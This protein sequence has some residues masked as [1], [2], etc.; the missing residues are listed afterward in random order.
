MHTDSKLLAASYLVIALIATFIGVKFYQTQSRAMSVLVPEQPKRVAVRTVVTR[1]GSRAL[2]QQLRFDLKRQR[3]Q[4]SELQQLLGKREEMLATQTRELQQ[5]TSASKK[6]DAEA[7]RYFALLIDLLHESNE[8]LASESAAA[9]AVTETEVILDPL[10]DELEPKSP[11]SL[12]TELALATWELDR[13]QSSDQE[14]QVALA[15]ATKRSTALQQSLVDTGEAAIP[16]L[17]SLLANEDAGLRAWAASSL[18]QV[19]KSS[20]TAMDALLVAVDDDDEQ[21]G[22]SATAAIEQISGG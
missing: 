13:L 1:E 10:A 19:G 5:Q 12:E 6:L 15:E 8:E 20:P 9:G 3:G 18:G 4:I 14:T 11:E 17:I 7:D 21:V 2:S 22:Q 16:V